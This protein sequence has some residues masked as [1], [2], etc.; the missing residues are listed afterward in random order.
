MYAFHF[1]TLKQ[2]F[3]VH[4]FWLDPLRV[5]KVIEQLLINFFF[6]KIPSFTHFWPLT[7]SVT[8]EVKND[9]VRVTMEEILNK[10]REMKISVGCMVWPWCR[11]FQIPRSLKILIRWTL[12]YTWLLY[13][14]KLL[15]TLLSTT[16]IGCFRHLFSIFLSISLFPP[17]S[18]LFLY[19]LSWK[20]FDKVKKLRKWV[21]KT[22][23]VVLTLTTLSMNNSLTELNVA[24]HSLF[25]YLISVS[26]L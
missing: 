2:C 23:K 5:F 24:L 1:R 15:E 18:H 25:C 12:L 3:K 22:Q 13:C 21:E 26:K 11:V 16:L 9:Y 7:A 6:Q 8:S 19:F 17:F 4:I 10:I 14:Q 20:I